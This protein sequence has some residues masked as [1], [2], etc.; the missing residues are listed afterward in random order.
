MHLIQQHTFDIHCSSQEFGKELQNQLR[1]LLEKEFYPQLEQLFNKY[2]IKNHIWSIDL[3]NIEVSNLSKKYWKQELIVKSLQQ[4]EDYLIRNSFSGQWNESNSDNNVLIS[5]SNQAIGLFFHFLKTGRLPDNCI[6]TDIEAIVLEIKIDKLFI[7]EL[8]TN[9]KN[10]PTELVRWIFSVPN[11]FKRIFFKK[12]KD[13]SN[14]TAVLLS[15]ILEDTNKLEIE[16]IKKNIQKLNQDVNLKKQWVEFIQWLLYL[17]KTGVSSD[18]LTKEFILFS[19]KY[20]ELEAIDLKH[21]TQ[22]ILKKTTT[23]LDTNSNEINLFF[24][25]VKSQVATKINS[26]ELMNGHAYLEI[27]NK[28][29]KEN[30]ISNKVTK[31]NE[32]DTCTYITNGGLVLLHP[33]LKS[34]F[35]QLNLCDQEGNWIT[36]V[37]QHKAILLTQYLVDGTTRIHE[38][39]LALNKILCGFSVSEIVNVKLKITKSEKQKGIRLLEA[40]KAHWKVMNSS[41]I[42]ALQQTFLKREAKLDLVKENGYELWIEEKGVD[43][44]LEQLPWGIGMIQTLW[45]E[46]YLNCH[47]S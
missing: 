19:E 39:D 34:L 8:V 30:G 15:A 3:L 28:V 29:T 2:E 11:S 9:F 35:E 18:Y 7:K 22:Y 36:K 24:Q 41:S 27:N 26:Q 47:W 17:K 10:N 37:S 14:E 42:E 25:V 16:K 1:L 45:M 5:K 44:L 33:F 38:S 6:S 32:I 23:K 12:T 43:I 13:F 21:I 46:N 4:I 20:W 40:V 31:E